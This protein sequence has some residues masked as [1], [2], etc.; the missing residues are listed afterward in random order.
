MFTDKFY[1]VYLVPGSVSWSSLIDCNYGGDR[2][3]QS[4]GEVISHRNWSWIF[5]FI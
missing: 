4:E 1:L 2:G 3:R 5:E